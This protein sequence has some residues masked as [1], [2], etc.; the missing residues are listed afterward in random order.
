[1]EINMKK[2]EAFILK[3]KNRPGFSVILNILVF[4]FYMLVFFPVYE[5]NDD[6]GLLTLVSGIKGVHDP[7]MVYIN[8]ILGHI[9][10]FLY[11]LNQSIPW[12]AL[13][14]YM[15]LFCSFTA[16][17]Y[18]LL[19]RLKP[20][21]SFWFVMIFLMFFAYEGYVNIQYTKSAGIITAGGLTLLFYT[22]FQQKTRRVPYILGFL[23]A[24][25]GSMYRVSQFF[26]ELGLF[27]ALGV[28]FLF[29]LKTIAPDKERKQFFKCIGTFFLLALVAAGFWAIDRTTYQSGE[30][31]YYLDYNAA[32]VEL[33]DYG[34]P[35][36]DKNK[37]EYMELGLD[38]SAHKL[39]K[40]WT[41]SDSE[42]ITVDVMQSLIELKTPKSKNLSL[43]K[44]YLKTM[45]KGVL[46]IPVFWCFLLLLV[47]WAICGKHSA[48]AFCTLI[49]EAVFIALVYLFLYYRGRCLIN[50]VDV[51]I[52]LAGVIVLFWIFDEAKPV[53]SSTV[54]IGLFCL[55]LLFTQ[56]KWH[57]DWRISKEAAA[58]KNKLAMREAIETIDADDTHLY[59]TKNGTISFFK[60]Y[61]IF[62]S[63]PSGI[64]D[65][66]Y[67]LGGWTAQ[68]PT[69]MRVLDRYG[70]TNPFREM[71]DNG[72]IYLI[73]NDIDLTMEYIHMWYDAGATAEEVNAIGKFKVYQIKGSSK[74]GASKSDNRD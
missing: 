22:L 2:F 20:A 32:R 19:N 40:R 51:G 59:L 58:V 27:T 62:D 44:G 24:L 66:L 54:S 23:L 15:F 49:Y 55:V 5:T 34:F 9:F 56:Y 37:E 8:T 52:W 50:R 14:Q 72:R 4:A 42:K 1:M 47:L 3:Y 21:S 28:Y 39:F 63:I 31:G 70:V 74:S 16:I 46:K 29:C 71:I 65:N 30:W 33:L 45:L 61:G 13:I 68:T 26:C 53:L 36:Y 11:G 41:H 64:G 48:G 73:D 25:A 60:A 57:D 17:T 10:A 38:A 7:H 43:I 12:Y 67:P 6:G 35:D 69:Y 18:V